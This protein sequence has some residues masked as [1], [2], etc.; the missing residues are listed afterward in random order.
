MKINFA[1][2]EVYTD[3]KKTNK[4]CID[5]REQISEMIYEVGSGIKD[6]ALA[7]KIYNSTSEVELTNEELEILKKYINQYCKP[8]FIEAFLEATKEKVEVEELKEDE[9]K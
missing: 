8:A 5:V 6:H 4:V 9:S 7:F 1:Q 3:I 2:L